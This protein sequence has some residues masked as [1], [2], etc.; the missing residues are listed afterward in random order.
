MSER[1]VREHHR[2]LRETGRFKLT[3]EQEDTIN[4]NLR[5]VNFE[6]EEDNAPTMDL[7]ILSW[8]K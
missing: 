8:R 6:L 2:L 4:L 7:P 1:D 5:G 3:K